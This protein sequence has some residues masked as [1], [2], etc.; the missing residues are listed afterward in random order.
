MCNSAPGHN[1]W[2]KWYGLIVSAF[3]WFVATHYLGDKQIHTIDVWV[4]K[5]ETVYFWVVKKE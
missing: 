2:H 3:R 1:S 4:V 5:K